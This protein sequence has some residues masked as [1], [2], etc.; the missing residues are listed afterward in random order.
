MSA[1]WH[2]ASNRQLFFICYTSIR[3]YNPAH[4]AGNTYLMYRQAL[5]ADN[6]DHTA[7]WL[8]I[9]SLEAET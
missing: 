3:I 2:T 9:T 1:A 8:D 7:V 4:N 6:I 5:P